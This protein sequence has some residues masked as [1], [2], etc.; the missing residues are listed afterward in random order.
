MFNS[1]A[2]SSTPEANDEMPQN[3]AIS[4]RFLHLLPVCGLR[5]DAAANANRKVRQ[6]V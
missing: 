2:T 4:R 1:A 3:P 6:G 5:Y